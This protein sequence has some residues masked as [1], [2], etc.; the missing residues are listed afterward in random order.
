MNGDVFLTSGQI[1]FRS[2]SVATF[3]Q[4]RRFAFLS[5]ISRIF[6]AGPYMGDLLFKK[7]VSMNYFKNARCG[8]VS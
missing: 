8:A 7:S 3:P 2:R 6:F 4:R 1:L 5:K